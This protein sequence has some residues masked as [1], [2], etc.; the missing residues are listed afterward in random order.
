MQEVYLLL[1]TDQ[2]TQFYGVFLLHICRGIW[3]N[4]DLQQRK[5]S[6]VL[7]KN[8]LKK[9]LSLHQKEEMVI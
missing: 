6:L 3:S 8:T 1:K 7:T 2:L 5:F 9:C 4:T